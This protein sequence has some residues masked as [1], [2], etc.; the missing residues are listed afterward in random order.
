MRRK[1]VVKGNVRRADYLRAV[2]TD[3]L[4]EEVPIIFSN[5]G[6]Y[7]NQTKALPVNQ[8]ARD[9]VAAILN[10]ERS[11]TVPYRY[12][13]LKDSKSVRGLSLI[14]P[15]AQTAVADF[16]A[17][18]DS[19]I[20]YYAGKSEASLRAPHKVGSTFFVRGPGS[21]RNRFKNSGIDTVSIET[22]VS[23]P[24]S[25]FAYNKMRRA[26]EFFNSNEYMHLEKKFEIFRMLDVSKCF[27][28]IYTHTMYWAISDVEIA[29]DNTYSAGFA[30]DFD[31]LMQSMNYNET[32]GICIG[33]EVSRIFAE[34]IFKST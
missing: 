26:H 29:K 28:S 34:L 33:P 12:N 27:G 3:T 7:V 6:F 5:D 4:P 13:V 20:C 17:R 14:H 24:A 11:Y 9:F 1:V 2:V 21:E 18:Y 22:T 8:A 23:N 32:N 25:Y 16:Y 19:L 10:P 31:R 15:S 30:N